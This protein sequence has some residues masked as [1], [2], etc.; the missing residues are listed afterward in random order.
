MSTKKNWKCKFKNLTDFHKAFAS[1]KQCIKFLEKKRWPKGVVSPFDKD[2]KVYKRGDGQYRCGTTGKNFNVRVGTIFHGTKVPLYSWFWAI[3]LLTSRKKGLSS[4][5]L[6]KDIS[7]TQKTAWEMLQKIR[8]CFAHDGKVLSG[9]IELDETFVGGKNEYRHMDKKMGTSRGRSHED[10][11][12]V[13]GMLERGGNVVCKVTGNTKASS[14]TQPI[15]DNVDKD[16]VLYMD[17]WQGYNQVK[18]MYEHKVVDH[19]KNQYV[20]GDATTNR[21]EGFWGCS[22]RSLTGNYNSVEGSHMQRYF[23][24]F[25]FRYNT[26]NVSDRERF[27]I[28]FNNI[29]HKETYNDIKNE[30][31]ERNRGKLAPIAA[32]QQAEK[33]ERKAKAA[34]AK[35]KKQAKQRQYAA[36]YKAK[37][38]AKQQAAIQAAYNQGLQAGQT[39]SAKAQATQLELFADI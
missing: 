5:Q 1:E 30:H 18:K 2:A 22:K 11:V 37:K 31:K 20:D 21:I 3:Y 38:A 15:L 4:V 25:A 27:D 14:L 8:S 26:R 17:E 23:D 16:A 10:K 32:R 33:K 9:E 12:A 6:S 28:F 34:E 36:N 19:G 7:V 35:A 24:E 29:E 13:L 39:Q